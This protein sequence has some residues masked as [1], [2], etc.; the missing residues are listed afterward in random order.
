MVIT[1]KQNKNN[2]AFADTE[3]C[4]VANE[5]AA[6]DIACVPDAMLHVSETNMCVRYGSNHCFQ[7]SGLARVSGTRCVVDFYR[8]SRTLLAAFNR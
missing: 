1:G 2:L 5:C 4:F 3:C 7:R 6:I 8:K